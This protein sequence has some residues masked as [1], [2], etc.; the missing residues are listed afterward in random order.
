MEYQE[1]QITA[2]EI[3]WGISR[4]NNRE[5]RQRLNGGTI[6]RK[7][8]AKIERYASIRKKSKHR[9]RVFVGWILRNINIGRKNHHTRSNLANAGRKAKWK[10]TPRTQRRRGESRPI[11]YFNTSEDRGAKMP[12]PRRYVGEVWET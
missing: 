2:R 12:R 9:A 4:R 5:L 3:Q 8:F 7:A 11:I 1:K 6:K 10:Y